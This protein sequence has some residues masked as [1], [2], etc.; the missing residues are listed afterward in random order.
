MSELEPPDV[1]AR[2]KALR[3]QRG[4]SMRGLARLC[5]LSPNAISLIE[6][7]ASSPSVSTLHRIATALK[8]PITAFFEGPDEKAQMIVSRA[9]ARPYTGN[10]Q[11]MLESLGSGL[12]GQSL[13]PFVV[14]LEPGAGSGNPVM[15]HDGHELVY[16]LQGEVEYEVAGKS[17]RLT[18]GDSVLFEARLEHRWH[19]AGS[20][21][22]KFLLVFQS[23][24][25]GES[26]EEHL[27]V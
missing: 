6:R 27:S 24:F 12:E 5:G 16:C 13:E 9:G 11:V 18:A 7:G 23:A 14:T 8:V 3:E 25:L 10:I 19:N 4:L 1:G 17:C 21:P 22:T 20:E 2:V 26:V 15:I